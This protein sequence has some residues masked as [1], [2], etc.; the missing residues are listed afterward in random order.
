MQSIVHAN[1]SYRHSQLPGGGFFDENDRLLL[2]G[3]TVL[4][5]MERAQDVL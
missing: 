5:A 4:E 1:R 2:A 3:R